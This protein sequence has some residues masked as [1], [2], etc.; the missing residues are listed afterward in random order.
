MA[1]LAPRPLKCCTMADFALQNVEELDEHCRG[2]ENI[3]VFVFEL[4]GGIH[5]GSMIVISRG[6][7]R[8]AAARVSGDDGLP[9]CLHRG[10]HRSAMTDRRGR[11]PEASPRAWPAEAM[12][13]RLSRGKQ[14]GMKCALG[15]TDHE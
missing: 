3:P 11:W 15:P 4:L 5:R 10:D 9:I 14:D 12:H 2:H 7:R 6:K 13:P 8:N 1:T